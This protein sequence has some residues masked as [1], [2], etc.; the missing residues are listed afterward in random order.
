MLQK[1]AIPSRAFDLVTGAKMRSTT[2]AK[3]ARRNSLNGL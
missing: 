2:L 3:R 1:V